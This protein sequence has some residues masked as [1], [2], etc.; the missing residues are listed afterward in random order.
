[1]LVTLKQLLFRNLIDTLFKCYGVT[2]LLICYTSCIISG[3][4]AI[5]NELL[6]KCNLPDKVSRLDDCS[7]SFFVK[8]YKGLLG[9]DL[10]GK[11]Y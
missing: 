7:D 1:M 8:V 6:E 10:H 11:G 3:F 4:I 2:R 5:A 9:D